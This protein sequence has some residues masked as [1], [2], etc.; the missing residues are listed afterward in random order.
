MICCS[1]P[2]GWIYYAVDWFAVWLRVCVRYVCHTLHLVTFTHVTLRTHY[3][4]TV[5]LIAHTF[6]LRG[7]FVIYVLYQFFTLRL[8]LVTVLLVIL[9][10]FTRLFAVVYAA[11]YGLRSRLVL[12]V[13]VSLRVYCVYHRPPTYTLPYR[14]RLPGCPYNIRLPGCRYGCSTLDLPTFTTRG[15]PVP[16]PRSCCVYCHATFTRSPAFPA[17]L[18]PRTFTIRFTDYDIC[19]VRW[20]PYGRVL[21]VCCS[22]PD[23]TARFAVGCAGLPRF[24]VVRFCLLRWLVQL[25]YVLYL[26]LLRLHY[27]GYGWLRFAVCRCWLQLFACRFP[28]YA[29]TLPVCPV[30]T[31][32]WLLPAGYRHGCVWLLLRAARFTDVYGLPQHVPVVLCVPTRCLQH[33]VTRICC[34]CSDLILPFA[35]HCGSVRCYLAGCLRLRCRTGYGWF[36]C[37]FTAHYGYVT[38]RLPFTG[39]PLVR[40]PY[41]PTVCLPTV[42]A[43]VLVVAAHTRSGRALPFLPAVAAPATRLV[44]HTCRLPHPVAGWL[45]RFCGWVYTTRT[46]LLLPLP[47]VLPAVIHVYVRSGSR[48]GYTYGYPRVCR[49]F[50]CAYVAHAFICGSRVVHADSATLRFTA[51]LRLFGCCGHTHLLPACRIARLGYCYVYC[52]HAGYTHTLPRLLRSVPLHTTRSFVD[53]APHAFTY[54]RSVTV[55]PVTTTRLRLPF[56]RLRTVAV[57][58]LRCT[59]FVYHHGCGSA[60]PRTFTVRLP[61]IRTVVRCYHHTCTFTVLTVHV[62]HGYPTHAV[63]TRTH[64]TRLRLPPV[65]TAFLDYAVPYTPLITCT[66]VPVAFLVAAARA[67]THVY[68]LRYVATAFSSTPFCGCCGSV[69]CTCGSPH[70]TVTRFVADVPPHL[71]AF[72]ARFHH[73]THTTF[74]SHTT[75]TRWFR[76]AFALR[77]FAVALRYITRL[78][79][80]RLLVHRCPVPHAVA[81]LRCADVYTFAVYAAVTAVTVVVGY[82]TLGYRPVDCRY[83]L[84]HATRLPRGCCLPT[85]L[86]LPH[87]CYYGYPL[88]SLPLRFTLPALLRFPLYPGSD[89]AVVTVTV[90]SRFLPCCRLRC[91]RLRAVPHTLVT[92]YW[93]RFCLRLRTVHVLTRYH[94]WLCVGCGYVPVYYVC[95]THWLRPSAVLTLPALVTGSTH[96]VA[97]GLLPVL[98]AILR[99]VRA[100][101][102]YVTLRLRVAGYRLRLP[103]PLPLRLPAVTCTVTAHTRG[104][105]TTT[106]PVT[107]T[108]AYVYLPGYAYALRL[109][110][111]VGCPGWFVL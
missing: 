108:F 55:V 5:L 30:T 65:V 46:Y 76:F 83:V 93:L 27:T 14:L 104:S 64:A 4:V 59:R 97:T 67:F 2:F 11:L 84:T 43:H 98:V 80:T 57:G 82:R 88:R 72:T 13:P 91:L 24:P 50:G 21:A 29:V 95:L 19:T 87:G 22:P 34:L 106:V 44:P 73:A 16:L 69:R 99:L 1:L 101:C 31:R 9:R 37:A 36:T 96:L 107:A 54:V 3:L 58:W 89:F 90:G 40:L 32:C 56:A 74:F 103:T 26:A 53:Y 68:A 78:D 41:R 62:P 86:T 61:V 42:R 39:L 20:L 66:V 6:S 70:T 100:G 81:L 79:Y 18:L 60:V 17:R 7:Y 109:R 8:R 49:L 110:Y 77:L 94:R 10:S 35:L 102:G 63:T 75:T 52:P 71:R 33:A 15:L 111:T 48:F 23:Y 51:V 12:T 92:P 28:V 45:Y 85:H 38:V 105:V 47:A 25:R